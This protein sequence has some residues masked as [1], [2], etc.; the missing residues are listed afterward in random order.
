VTKQDP[1]REKLDNEIK[2]FLTAVGAD[3]VNP[4]YEK[5]NAKDEEL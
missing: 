4:M 1:I 5:L 3:N 2:M